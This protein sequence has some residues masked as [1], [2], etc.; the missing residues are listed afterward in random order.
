MP[1]GRF[2]WW[3]GLCGRDF[4]AGLQPSGSVVAADP[5]RWHPSEQ[6]PLAGDP[7]VRTPASKN[8]RRGPRRCPGL[9]CG[10]AVGAKRQ[11]AAERATAAV[12]KMRVSPLRQTMKPFASGRDDNFW[13][14][15]PRGAVHCSM[16]KAAIAG[17]FFKVPMLWGH[18]SSGHTRTYLYECIRGEEFTVVDFLISRGSAIDRASGPL[19]SCCRI[20][21]AAPHAGMGRASGPKTLPLC[22]RG[23][24]RRRRWSR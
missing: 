7:A 23:L 9:G 4:R 21:G 17:G 1:V 3:C 20:R 6:K 24:L 8:A 2:A 5:G 13:A 11:I 15:W 12:V 18:A 22:C 19:V 14:E 10:R 16:E